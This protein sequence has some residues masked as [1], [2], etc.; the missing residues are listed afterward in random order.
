[1]VKSTPVSEGIRL[2]HAA[3]KLQSAA[4]RYGE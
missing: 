1:L 4:F 3:F 2:K